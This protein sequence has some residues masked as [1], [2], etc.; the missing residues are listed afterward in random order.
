[1]R[2]MLSIDSTTLELVWGLGTAPRAHA[3]SKTEAALKHRCRAMQRE[4]ENERLMPGHE[5]DE[6]GLCCAC[7]RTVRL[8]PCCHASMCTECALRVL[9]PESG[10]RDPGSVGRCPT[11]RAVVENVI[12]TG[13]AADGDEAPVLPVPAVRM[14][15]FDPTPQGEPLTIFEFVLAVRGEEVGTLCLWMTINGHLQE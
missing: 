8:L 12:W 15:T 4:L 9:A 7:P 11:C 10:G 5:G 3:T 1:M 13:G 14:Q 2:G 6:C